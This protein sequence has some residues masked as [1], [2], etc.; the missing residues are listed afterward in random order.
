M[1]NLLK[2]LNVFNRTGE[3]IVQDESLEEHDKKYHPEGFDPKSD[4]CS[5]RDG[6]AKKD[7][8]DNVETSSAVSSEGSEKL[9]EEIK[10]GIDNA[11]K[12]A[13]IDAPGDLFISDEGDHF[14][15][16]GAVVNPFPPVNYELDENRG[17]RDVWEDEAEIDDYKKKYEDV[18]YDIA[19][20][21]NCS[22]DDIDWQ[23]DEDGRG[24]IGFR[25]YA[26]FKKDDD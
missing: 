8:E 14:S 16:E 6:M 26:E 17:Y 23:S 2:A 22:C 25:F 19:E 15:V 18:I 10:D 1:P 7:G 9:E 21:F 20:K 11:C 12:E 5:K 3:R 13:K 24:G 4:S